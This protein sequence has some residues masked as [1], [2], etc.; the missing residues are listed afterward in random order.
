MKLIVLGIRSIVYRS[1]SLMTLSRSIFL[2][3]ILKVFR[4]GQAK[5]EFLLVWLGKISSLS[6]H[7]NDNKW[8]KRMSDILYAL[9]I[10]SFMFITLNARPGVTPVLGWRTGSRAIPG[11]INEQTLSIYFSVWWELKICFLV[12][13]E[14]ESQ[15][16][17]RSY[18]DASLTRL[19]SLI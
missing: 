14:S 19:E 7:V 16:A 1:R 12:C 18:D 6:R 4:I 5:K 2:D 8:K 10:G 13:G 9:A 15:L 17:V 11:W 3:K